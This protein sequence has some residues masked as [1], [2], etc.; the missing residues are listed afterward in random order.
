MPC[1]TVIFFCV[2]NTVHLAATAAG[3]H[4]TAS[5]HGHVREVCTQCISRVVLTA[6]HSL[7]SAC[8]L[9]VQ[10][11]LCYH[12]LWCTRVGCHVSGFLCCDKLFLVQVGDKDMT[13]LPAQCVC[14]ITIRL[15]HHV[16]TLCLVL[17]AE[18]SMHC[19]AHLW[20]QR[21]CQT[22]G[23]VGTRYDMYLDLL[24]YVCS[25]AMLQ[26]ARQAYPSWILVAGHVRP[27]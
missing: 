23:G 18:G 10:A 13:V 21:P 17:P 22:G 25:T 11:Y 6:Q 8:R 14:P 2:A 16:Q 24:I 5:C 19:S 20:F 27:M 15:C 4:S 1:V 12:H 3:T 26:H 7:F 9:P